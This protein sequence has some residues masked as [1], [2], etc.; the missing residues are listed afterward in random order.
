[1]ARP[2]NDV[3]PSSGK[4]SQS[5]AVSTLLIAFSMCRY[6]YIENLKHKLCRTQC[7]SLASGLE[8]ALER[9]DGALLEDP[10]GT[11]RS[12]WGGGGRVGNVGHIRAI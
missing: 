11:K 1:M 5:S 8:T 7:L 12:A 4:I 2:R 6:V 9:Q 10:P 3:L